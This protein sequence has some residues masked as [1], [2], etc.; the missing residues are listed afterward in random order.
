MDDDE[1]LALVFDLGSGEIKCGF[2]GD[3]SPRGQFPNVL[4][5]PRTPG[6][7]V[8]LRYK[9]S[10]VGDAAQ[11]Y[12]GILSLQY[13][14]ENGVVT[15]VDA[16]EQVFIHSFHNELRVFPEEHNV[17]LTE[18]PFNPR[19]NRTCLTQLMFETF[20][21]PGVYIAFPALL[22]CCVNR[23]SSVQIDI[24][25]SVTTIVPTEE[26]RIIKAGVIRTNFA[27]RQLTNYLGRLMTQRG[28]YLNRSSDVAS[29]SKIKEKLCYVPLNYNKEIYE[30]TTHSKFRKT[31]ELSDGT[32]IMLDY[33]RF[34]C[35]EALFQPSFVGLEMPGI[36]QLLYESINKT[37]MNLRKM[38]MGNI[39]LVG[40]STLFPGFA[41]RMYQEM[42]NLAPPNMKV[43]II[44]APDRRYTAWYGGSILAS[45]TTSAKMWI[46]KQ[47]YDECGPSI[48]FSK[49]VYM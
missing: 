41:D 37:D 39:F 5:H 16:I 9:E 30:S 14:I 47:E 25:E 38:F 31:T 33:E 15:S 23:Y 20:Q 13:P 45:L 6:L 46:T 43:R 32:P 11:Q 26:G 28:Y 27:G 34:Q 48:A 49:C 10:Y 4:G 3:D 17:L 18:A 21:V 1:S 7:M 36:H 44:S 2:A 35:P 22:S 40:G 19:S 8:G 12:R 24:G 42:T 29:T